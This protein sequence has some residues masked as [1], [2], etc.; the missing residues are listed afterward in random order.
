MK[1]YLIF[2]FLT[3]TTLLNAQW[4]NDEVAVGLGFGKSNLS[5]NFSI[6][7]KYNLPKVDETHAYGPMFRWQ[8]GWSN[9]VA[10]NQQSSF[11]IWGP[12]AFYHYRFLDV[13]FAGV[14]FEYLRTPFSFT[15]LQPF[16]KW[17]PILNLGAGYS[18]SFDFVRVNF[19]LFYDVIDNTNS[20]MR[21]QYFM[22]QKNEAG[23][24]IRILPV[25]YKLQFFFPLGE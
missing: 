19:G 23:Q 4:K 21:P 18:Q 15:L 5:G 24:V 8:R 20:P 14:E 7:L 9:N 12:G 6:N 25:I 11:T 3:F 16:N 10:T 13:L 17:V 2:C 1:K 22:K